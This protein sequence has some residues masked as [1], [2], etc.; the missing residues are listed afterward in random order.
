MDRLPALSLL[1]SGRMVVRA[2][3]AQP[4]HVSLIEWLLALSQL[5]LALILIFDKYGPLTQKHRGGLPGSLLLHQL[6]HMRV[7]KALHGCSIS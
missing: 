4:V 6:Y 2:N 5:L 3:P 7:L 1:R